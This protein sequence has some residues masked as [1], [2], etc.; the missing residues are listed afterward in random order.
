MNGVFQSQNASASLIWMKTLIFRMTTGRLSEVGNDGFRESSWWNGIWKRVRS[1]FLSKMKR[2]IRW[3]AS[4][5][6]GRRC[7]LELQCRWCWKRHL[8]HSGMLSSQMAW[9]CHTTS[10]LEA[11]W[12]ECSRMYIWLQKRAAGS[13]SR[14]KKTVWVRKTQEVQGYWTSARHWTSTWLW[15]SVRRLFKDKI[16]K[17]HKH[18]THSTYK[19]CLICGIDTVLTVGYIVAILRTCARFFR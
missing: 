3:A 6:A 14:S 2:C 16:Y 15:T 10:L 1:S 13:T 8:C 18:G 9:W 11:A 7:F 19:I 17:R 12:N 5:R 4:Y